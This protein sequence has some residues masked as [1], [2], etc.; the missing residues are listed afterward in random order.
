[1]RSLLKI[2]LLLVGLFCGAAESH[3]ASKSATPVQIMPLGDSITQGQFGGGYRAPLCAALIE[4]G[5]SFR[6][7]GTQTINSVAVLTDS[8]NQNHEGHGGYA[9]S[10]ILN[11]LDGG[12]KNGGHWLDG[13]PGV[14]EPI[15]PDIILLMIGTNDLGSHKR[16]VEPTLADYDKLLDKLS[17]MRPKATIIASTLIPY[18]GSIEKY[19]L[20]E[21]HQLEF[22]AAL[23]A[24]IERHRKAGQQVFFYDMRT[25]VGPEH[26]S[27]DGVHPNQAGHDAL[28]AGWLEA[29]EKLALLKQ[30]RAESKR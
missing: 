4:K 11:N 13:L 26:I 6:F 21:Q 9:L 29:L 2:S 15:Y 18:T 16:E 19:P 30:S 22:N 14:R 20:R 24:L 27:A 7:V 25:K 28:A 3:A 10:H 5:Y 1:M 23:P 12:T 8:G 17:A